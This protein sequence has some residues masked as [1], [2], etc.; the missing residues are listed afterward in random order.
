M[1]FIVL[2]C[3]FQLQQ[4]R[5]RSASGVLEDQQGPY[6]SFDHNANNNVRTLLQLLHQI[7]LYSICSIEGK[8]DFSDSNKSLSQKQK[9]L[10][11]FDCK[12]KHILS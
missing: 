8:F 1:F 5:S 9:K 10:T 6:E 12:K 4:Q 3:Y 2:T 7:F 11:T